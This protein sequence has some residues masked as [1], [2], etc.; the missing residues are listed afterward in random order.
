[1]SNHLYLA[2][3]SKFPE[4]VCGG[5]LG[6]GLVLAIAVS[7]WLAHS[8][9]SGSINWSIDWWRKEKGVAPVWLQQELSGF[10]FF[11]LPICNTQSLKG[12]DMITNCT[13][14]MGLHETFLANHKCAVPAPA[15]LSGSVEVFVAITLQFNFSFWPVLLPSSP[16]PHQCGSQEHSQQIFYMPT[17]ESGSISQRIWSYREMTKKKKRV[18]GKARLTIWIHVIAN[19]C[20]K[21]LCHTDSWAP[22]VRYLCIANG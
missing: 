18:V 8:K 10:F 22:H 15:V 5:W 1:M 11:Y 20:S 9:Y 3:N 17:L 21:S 13:G 2:W 12:M 16:I 19:P 6:T 4:G 7:T 14:T